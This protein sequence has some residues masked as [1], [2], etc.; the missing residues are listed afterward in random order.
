MS[1]FAKLPNEIGL[2]LRY[3]NIDFISDVLFDA[4]K[5]QVKIYYTVASRC[6]GETLSESIFF[7][8]EQEAKDFVYLIV[9]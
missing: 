4:G 1:R 9:G 5:L 7:K 3:V 6:E 2:N 8:T